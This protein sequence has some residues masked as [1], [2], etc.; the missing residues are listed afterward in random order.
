MEEGTM[1]TATRRRDPEATDSYMDL[2]RQFP[3]RPIRTRKDYAVAA[4]L[5]DRLAL[6]DDQMDSGQSDYLDTLELLI[7]SYD[8]QQAKIEPEGRSPLERLKYLLQQNQ[9]SA[10]E[11]GDLLGSR[12]AA[13]MILKGDR[14]MSKDHIRKLAERFR[15]DAGYFL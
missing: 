2:I 10:A 14:Q 13:S 1:N 5:V 6:L 3:L 15:V 7:E 4:G 12:P 11:L 8:E 9:M